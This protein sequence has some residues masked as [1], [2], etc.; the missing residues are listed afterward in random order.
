MRRKLAE[1]IASEAEGYTIS[2]TGSF[3]VL[4][5]ECFKPWDSYTG[6]Q[7]RFNQIGTGS[8]YMAKELE[9]CKKEVG[10]EGKRAYTVDLSA[11]QVTK[12]L[13]LKSW[14]EL[15]PRLSGSLLVPSASGGYEPTHEIANWAH[16]NKF[17]GIRF[18]SQHDTS[19]ENLVLWHDRVA[20]QQSI[21]L[22]FNGSTAKDERAS[23][24]GRDDGTGSEDA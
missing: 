20:I 1:K 6:S 5:D 22:E 16:Q 13:D 4:K 9:T 12:V 8:L 18:A 3:F 11:T 21:F 15:N 24:P 10:E 17:Q 2:V 7:H 19:A 23:G 14:S